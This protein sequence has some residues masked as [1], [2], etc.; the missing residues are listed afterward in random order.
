MNIEITNAQ[1]VA[2]NNLLAMGKKIDAIKA[3]REYHRPA[4]IG[5]DGYLYPCTLNLRE[6]KDAIEHRMGQNNSPSAK[7]VVKD[8][9]RIVSLSISTK[10]G[11][12]DIQGSGIVDLPSSSTTIEDLRKIVETWDRLMK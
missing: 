10:A 2:I 6:A 8:E 9:F 11:Y 12:L 7:L 5:N 4:G 3:L 1:S